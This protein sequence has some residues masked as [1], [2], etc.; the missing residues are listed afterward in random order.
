MFGSLSYLIYELVFAGGAIL[1]EWVFHGWFLWSRVKTILRI[2]IFFVLYLLITDN[3]ALSLGI[4]AHDRSKI[5]NIWILG[6]PLEEVTF[7]IL[8]AVAVSSAVLIFA[9]FEDKGIRMRK[10]PLYFFKITGL[11]QPLP[12]SNEIK[13]HQRLFKT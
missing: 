5:L 13:S 6:I 8:V 7:S 9:N 4:W 3:V 2:V 11:T 1:I 10:W 12:I